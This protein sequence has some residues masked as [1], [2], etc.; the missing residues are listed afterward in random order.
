MFIRSYNG[1]TFFYSL[2]KGMN[3][4]KEKKKI[5]YFSPKPMPVTDR[6]QH[7]IIEERR[8]IRETL[9]KNCQLKK[10]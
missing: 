2:Q 10:Y 4:M 6:S 1:Q 5:V 9:L 8:K 7:E 3:R